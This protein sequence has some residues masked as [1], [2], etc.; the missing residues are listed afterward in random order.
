MNKGKIK[1]I[2]NLYDN[3]YLKGVSYNVFVDQY[4]YVN[5]DDNHGCKMTKEQIIEYFEGDYVNVLKRIVRK[6]KLNK[7][8]N[9]KTD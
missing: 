2:K 9:I 7:I 4:I 8:K 3:L 6:E 1:C 5:Y